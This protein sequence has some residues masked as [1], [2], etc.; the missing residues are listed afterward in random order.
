MNKCQPSRTFLYA[1]KLIGPFYNRTNES[2]RHIIS[3][4]INRQEPTRLIIVCECQLYQY[5]HSYIPGRSKNVMAIAKTTRNIYEGI[6][7]RESTGGGGERCVCVFVCG[8]VKTSNSLF[9]I[10]ST[11]Y[12]LHVFTTR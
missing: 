2:Y 7:R 9:H 8:G 10:R 4:E 1:Q 11:S 5:S 12:T 6:V 3:R